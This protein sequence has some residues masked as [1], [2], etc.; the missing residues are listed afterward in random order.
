MGAY[1]LHT[2]KTVV[3]G[4]WLQENNTDRLITNLYTDSRRIVQPEGGLFIAIETKHRDGHLFIRMAYQRGIRHFLIHKDVDVSLCPDADF[5]R[6]DNTLKA[7]QSIAAFHRSRFKE[8]T[9]EKPLPVIGITGSNGKTIV[10]EWLYQLLHH[11]Y[12]IVRSPKSYN[13]AVGVP[14]SIWQIEPKHTLALFE[15]GI[16]EKGEMDVLEKMIQPTISILT[17]IGDAHREGFKD[18]Q[19][20]LE[21][22]A[23][24]FRSSD[25][26]IIPY[27]IYKQLPSLRNKTC[28]CWGED[29]A[30]DLRILKK[31]ET[32]GRSILV[33]SW[34]GE[35]FDIQLPF[36]DEA[37][38]QNALTCCCTCLH[39]GMSKEELSMLV[40]HL[41]PVRLRLEI[42]RGQQQSTIIN[43]SYSAD[44][45]SF[46]IA[47]SLLHQ[48][49]QHQRKTVILSDLVL[50]KDEVAASY[51]DLAKM[52]SSYGV[53]KVIAVGTEAP[54][55][56]SQL[57]SKEIELLCYDDTNHLLDHIYSL[58]FSDEAVLIK[59]ARSFE[60]EKLIPFMEQQVHETVLE[61]NMN[62]FQQNLKKIRG[63]LKPGVKTMAVVKAFG[64]GTGSYEMAN[65]LQEQGIDY[66]TVAFADEGVAL[67]KAGITVPIMVMNA[68]PGTFDALTNHLLEPELYSESILEAFLQ[69]LDKEGFTQYPVHI[70]IDTGM[71][72]LGFEKHEWQAMSEKLKTDLIHVRSVFS[73]LAA[74]ED[75]LEDDFTQQQAQAFDQ[76]CEIIRRNISTDFLRHLSNSSG[77][78]RHPHLQYDMVRA[79]IALYGF[80]GGGSSLQLEEVMTLRTTIAQIKKLMPGDTVGYNRKGKITRPTVIATIRVG[81]ADGYPRQLSN[82]KGNMIVNGKEVPVIGNVCMDMTMLDIT[83][84][85][86]VK[87]GDKVLVFG[88]DRSLSKL[89]AEANTIPYE[90]MTGIS[91]RVKRVYVEE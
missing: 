36:Q 86:G 81:Y 52:I 85:P 34:N 58:S 90:I 66:L 12:D 79:G 41:K 16:S 32:D 73:H 43:D 44:L 20:K 83:D 11:H 68:E 15:A 3:H 5:I 9:E 61:V 74:A 47:F 29:E 60:L 18:L 77:I 46:D 55:Y 31:T 33:L 17:S 54:A 63:V 38:I 8:T 88:K 40:S 23:M 45:T 7:L 76:A 48:Q 72:R 24:L 75:S 49:R 35:E 4:E 22:K 87:E 28:V 91:Q 59:G 53:Q 80:A 1:P 84:V 25:T 62:A 26:V 10:K 37:S 42:K 21:E 65:L 30:S 56:L 78:I 69:H 14:L 89:A 51:K 13:S 71:H 27:H 57:L 19:E 64:Y 39:L 50:P 67:R 82:G 6:A 70:K 2:I